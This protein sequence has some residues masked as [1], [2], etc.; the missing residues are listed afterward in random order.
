MKL[1]ILKLILSLATMKLPN[2]RS[3]FAMNKNYLI[4]SMIYKIQVNLLPVYTI[5]W[6]L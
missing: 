2:H 3:W 6:L 4:E 1:D 5:T